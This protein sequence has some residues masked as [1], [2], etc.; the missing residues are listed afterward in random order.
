MKALTG[1]EEALRRIEN[2]KTNPP[3]D[4]ALNLSYL[5]LKTIPV[6]VNI[7]SDLEI[8]YLSNNKISEIKNLESLVNLKQLE[9][10]FSPVKNA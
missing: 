6:E 5:E 9:R 4:K 8:L 3:E 2:Y 10:S 1:Y 7:L